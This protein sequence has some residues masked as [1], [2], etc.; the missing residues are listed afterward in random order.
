MSRKQTNDTVLKGH[1]VWDAF[2]K[3]LVHFFPKFDEWLDKTEDRREPG[4]IIYPKQYMMWIGI[5]LFMCKLSFLRQ[6]KY[7]FNT[8]EFIENLNNISKTNVETVVYHGTVNYFFSKNS[9]KNAEKLRKK[10]IQGLI[11]NKVLEKYRLFGYYLV[12]LDGSGHLSFGEKKHCEDCLSKTFED[13]KTIYYH[14]IV[15]AKL[16]TEFGLAFSI[17]NEFVNNEGKETDV[18]D[19]ELAAAYRLLE[20]LKSNYPQLRICLLMDS[21]YANQNIFAIAEKNGWKYIINFKEGSIPTVA[22][23]FQALLKLE[24]ENKKIIKNENIS[25]ELSW[26]HDIDHEGHKVNYIRCVEKNGSEIKTY[27][28]LTNFRIDRDNVEILA[29]KGGR[30]RWKIE[31]QGFNMQKN[32]GY[33]LEH[34]F[35]TNPRAI[36]SFYILMQIAHI[37]NQLVECGSLLVNIQKTFGSIKN[38]AVRLLDELK[39]FRLPKLEF[40]YDYSFYIK[41][42]S[43]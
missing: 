3:T 26:M 41:F 16:I 19:C 28:W 35:S 13:G 36:K 43:S 40:K 20:K 12:V 32:G 15:E 24:P 8:P 17:G 6:I 34:A 1:I 10:M 23:E 27:E 22:E 37:I 39:H 38:I 2:S 29:N 25:Q 30:Q 5:L 7:L 31:N 18:Q 9:E 14:N 42:N 4:K 11:R 21:L 33:N